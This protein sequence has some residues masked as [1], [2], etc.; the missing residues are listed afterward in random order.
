MVGQKVTELERGTVIEK[1]SEPRSYKSQTPN[2]NVLRRNRRQLR[3]LT[4]LP[5]HVH[6][7]DDMPREENMRTT[8][9]QQNHRHGDNDRQTQTNVTQRDNTETTTCHTR[10]GRVINRP[11]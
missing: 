3:S 6:F 4:P 1:C 8:P 11:Q 10:S 2:G 7:G 9:S 5:K